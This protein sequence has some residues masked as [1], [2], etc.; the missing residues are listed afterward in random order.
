MENKWLM[1]KEE[2][3]FKKILGC[4]NTTN[5]RNLVIFLMRL[6]VSGSITQENYGRLQ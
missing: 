1:I 5:L 3:S 2:I 6:D 4:T